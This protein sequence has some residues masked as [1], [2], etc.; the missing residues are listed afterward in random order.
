MKNQGILL[1]SDLKFNSVDHKKHCSGIKDLGRE[2]KIFS[3]DARSLQ[4][5]DK[6]QERRQWEPF[7]CIVQCGWGNSGAPKTEDV[8][9][10]LQ[11][12]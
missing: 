12:D 6:G 4:T 9:Q 10:I 8:E 3:F 11:R 1:L 5:Q 7:G 2:R